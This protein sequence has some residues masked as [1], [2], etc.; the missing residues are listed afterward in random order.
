MVVLSFTEMLMTSSKSIHEF[1]HLRVT[2]TNIYKLGWFRLVRICI[3]AG[4]RAESPVIPL[5]ISLGF[6]M[7]MILLTP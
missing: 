1:I 7:R 6:G 4:F 2:A 5:P 3:V